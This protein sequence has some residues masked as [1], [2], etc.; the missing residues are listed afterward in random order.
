MNVIVITGIG[1]M[2]QACARRIGSGSRLVLADIDAGLLETAAAAL[3]DDGYDVLPQVMDVAD[4][5]AV[6]ALASTAQ[7]AGRLHAVV[8][9][10]GL[11]PAMAST[12]RI[13]AVDLLGTAYVLD[14]FLPLAVENTVAVIIASMAGHL[15][16]QPPE[17]ERRL[18]T[19]PTDQLP[20]FIREHRADDPAQAYGIAKRGN[21]VRVEAVAPEWAARGARVISISPGLI[22]TP[23]GRL[24]MHDPRTAQLRAVSGVRRLGTPDDIAAAVEWLISPCAS[25]I[26]GTDVRV[27]GGVTAKMRWVPP[28]A[29]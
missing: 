5:A 16:P 23:M 22:A 24:E 3:A 1:G 11:S 20:D 12:E 18:A 9:T 10:A 7:S 4:A 21:H 29:T 28:T 26:T 19:T 14:A 27:D 13:Y 2:G 25:Y 15:F 17:L 6:D 8:H